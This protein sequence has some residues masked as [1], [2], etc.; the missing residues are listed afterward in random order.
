MS[1]PRTLRKT[2]TAA[3]EIYVKMTSTFDEV[4]DTIAAEIEAALYSDLTQNGLAFDTKI[5]SFEADFGGDAE[6]PLGQGIIEVEISYP[7]TEGSPEG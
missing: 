7:A 5:V 6:Q 4:L 3:I 2:L 1:P